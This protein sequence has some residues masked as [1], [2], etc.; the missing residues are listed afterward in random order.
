MIEVTLE[1]IQDWI[2]CEIDNDYLDY[3]IKGVS[4]YSRKI[5]EQNLFIPFKGEHVGG[6]TYV[7]Q[8][9]E[10]GA[11][12]ALCQKDSVLAPQISS[13]IIWVDDTLAALQQLAKAYL[14]F[15]NPFGIAVTGSNGKTTTRDMIEIV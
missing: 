13:P 15:V 10:D 7:N 12:G 2:P 3:T 5:E 14:A 6:H 1:Q 11:R 4:I 8:A 9:L